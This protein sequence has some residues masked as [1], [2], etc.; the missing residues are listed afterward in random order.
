MTDRESLVQLTEAYIRA[1]VRRDVGWYQANLADDFVCIDGDGVTM[2]KHRFVRGTV[3][4]SDLLS[5]KLTDIDVRS[6]G[7]IAIVR[8]TGSWTARHGA[9]GTSRYTN[10][11]VRIGDHWRVTAARQAPS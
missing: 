5:C 2:D 1:L 4:G 3:A 8:A 10:V 7:T 11:Y 6:Y 9:R